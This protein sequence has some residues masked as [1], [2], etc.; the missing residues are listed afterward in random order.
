MS[1]GISGFYIVSRISNVMIKEKNDII[2]FV[3]WFI[4]LFQAHLLSVFDNVKH[5]GF[6]EK[7]YDKILTII[8]QEGETVSLE[9][10]VNAQ[11]SGGI[12]ETRR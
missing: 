11:V 6:D 3:S 8:S 4:V 9:E 5:V 7:V 2:Q 1:Y 12:Q 10:P